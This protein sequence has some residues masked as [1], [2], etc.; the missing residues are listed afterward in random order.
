MAT[1][2][3]ER[4]KKR[5]R[6][7]PRRLRHLLNPP[8]PP[9]PKIT[10]VTPVYN[11]AKT[12]RATFESVLN[13]RYPN[14]EYI[15]VDGG[16]TDG[17]RSII[18]EYRLHFAH[19]ISEPDRGM[20]DAIAKGFALGTGTIYAYLNS[21]DL[22]EPGA[23][24]RVGHYFATHPRAAVI[25][26]EDTVDVEGWRIANRRQ[27]RFVDFLTLLRGHIL[28][29]AGIFFRRHVYEAVGGVNRSMKLA[30]DWDLFAR[31]ARRFTFHKLEGHRSCFRIRADQL[32][33]DMD[34]YFRE[35]AAARAQIQQT[36]TSLEKVRFRW[37][38]YLTR[39]A[40]WLDRK[41]SGPKLYFNLD[42]ADPTTFKAAPPPPGEAP[43]ED[44]PPP[45]CPL[46]RQPPDRVLFSGRDC[47]YGDSR[48]SH[49]YYRE[50]SHLAITHPPLSEDRLDAQHKHYEANPQAAQQVVL[51]SPLYASP[52]RC[53]RAGNRLDQKVLMHG[54]LQFALNHLELF[55]DVDWQEPTLND[56]CDVLSGLISGKEQPL[57]FLDAGCGEGALLDRLA[58]VTRW[59]LSGLESDPRAVETVRRKG[60]RVWQGRLLEAPYVIDADQHFDVIY[61]GNTLARV[62]EPMQAVRRL[63][64]MLRDGGLLIVSTPNLDS[65]QVEL[66]GPTWSQW[67]LP[68]HRHLFSKKALEQMAELAALRLVHCFTRSHPHATAMSLQLNELG[69]GGSVSPHAP[70]EP[71]LTATARALN[72]WAKLSWNWRGKGDYL[73]AAFQKPQ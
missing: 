23:L 14:L 55:V 69:L 6:S 25:Y 61:L 3:M 8:P 17:T 11:G 28:Y 37:Q 60:Y 16:S 47:R 33:A 30:G 36:L 20:Y 48:I 29:Q 7:L 34:G 42:A 39:L 66:F 10:I 18:D 50:D 2:T 5:I 49:V 43:P 13:Q 57:V 9:L 35:M 45:V 59:Y 22:F 64:P 27:P 40:N 19:V 72:I 65:A 44:A 46:T 1:T 12:L 53:F 67:Q 70:L 71:R 26:H 68:Y 15:V 54:K 56:L 24:S 4:V 32:S 63:A 62:N 41:R 51:P 58:R 21:D 31:M 38:H 52:F 73:V